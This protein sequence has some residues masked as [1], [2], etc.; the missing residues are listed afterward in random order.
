MP[1]SLPETVSTRSIQTGFCTGGLLASAA[2]IFKSRMTLV[3]PWRLLP[4]A[5]QEAAVLEQRVTPLAER[6]EVRLGV[7]AAGLQ[8]PERAEVREPLRH[9]RVVIARG[10]HADAPP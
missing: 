2:S 4:R 10:P 8:V 1:A 5:E 3:Q 7:V 9:P 6:G